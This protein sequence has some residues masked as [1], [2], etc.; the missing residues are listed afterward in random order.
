MTRTI[1][2]SVENRI[3]ELARIVN[4]F[5]ARGVRIET[6]TAGQADAENISTVTI[7]CDADVA[8][9]AQIV[10]LLDK[11]VRVLSAREVMQPEEQERE[12][13][14]RTLR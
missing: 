2:V 6:L 14:A 11:Q 9:A 7:A 1:V 12:N 13:D 5:A 8:T 4:V 3:G 10:R